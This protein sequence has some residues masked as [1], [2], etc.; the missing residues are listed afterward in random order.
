[1]VK[2]FFVV[3]ARNGKYVTE[4]IR[5]LEELDIPYVIVSGERVDH[6]KVIYRLP[7]GKYDAVNFSGSLIP[8]DVDIIAF[9]DVDARLSDFRP[10]LSHFRDTRVAIV[11]APELVRAGPQYNFFRLLNPLRRFLPL[12]GTGEL[13]MIRQEVLRKVLPLNAC[14][15]ED[16]YLMFKALELGY[17]V[18]FCEDCPTETERTK[19]GIEEENYKR[20]TVAGIYQALSFTKPPPLIRFLYALL[21]FTAA[22]LILMGRKGH[23]LYKGIL[24]GFL[25]YAR[26]DRSGAWK[27]A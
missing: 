13:M 20:R 25:D 15:A 26:G 1:M 2:L 11:F 6:P 19:T 9:N 22:L 14:K 16:T 5:E 3:F 12:A 27:A 4:K 24:L 21:P 10:M 7:K 23:H 18:V 17:K 8:Q